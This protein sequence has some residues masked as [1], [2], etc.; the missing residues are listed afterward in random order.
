MEM[1][2]LKFLESR[3]KNPTY[4]CVFH[5]SQYRAWNAEDAP[6]YLLRRWISKLNSVLC[7]HTGIQGI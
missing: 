5:A 7:L 1:E 4:V 2:E 3:D 6:K